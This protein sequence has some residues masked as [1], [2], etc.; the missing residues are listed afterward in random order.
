MVE[1]IVEKPYEIVVKNTVENII[2]NRY[3]V[4]KEVEKV[5]NKE[6]FVDVEKIVEKKKLMQKEQVVEVEKYVEVPFEVY[7][8][9]ERKYYTEVPMPQEKIVNTVVDKLVV[10]PHRTEVVENKIYVE[11]EVLVD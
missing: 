9:V 6:K 4:D 3:Y 8:D 1:R 2:E 11:K 10:R 7:Q 5:V